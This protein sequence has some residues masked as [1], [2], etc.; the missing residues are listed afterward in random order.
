MQTKFDYLQQNTKITSQYRVNLFCQLRDSIKQKF[1]GKTR[2]RVFFAW[3]HQS[4]SFHVQWLPFDDVTTRQSSTWPAVQNWNPVITSSSTFR[5][6]GF[7]RDSGT[8][9]STARRLQV[10]R[11]KNY[12]LRIVQKRIFITRLEVIFTTVRG[13]HYFSIRNK[14]YLS[15]VLNNLKIRCEKCIDVDWCY[16]QTLQDFALPICLKV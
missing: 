4:T 1:R 11:N 16:I 10:G 15:N 9:T 2:R 7:E 5:T 3:P 6:N 13:K 8:T 12:F 14:D